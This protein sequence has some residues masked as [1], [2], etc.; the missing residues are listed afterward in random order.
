MVQSVPRR[1]AAVCSTQAPPPLAGMDVTPKRTA[2]LRKRAGSACTDRPLNTLERTCYISPFSGME[3][4]KEADDSHL[5]TASGKIEAIPRSHSSAA[6]ACH[7]AM[8]DGTGEGR[9]ERIPWQ[10]IYFNYDSSLLERRAIQSGIQMQSRLIK[11]R[12]RNMRG[13]PTS[14]P[15]AKSLI[16]THPTTPMMPA[17][18]TSP[19]KS[20]GEDPDVVYVRHYGNTRNW[21][22]METGIFEGTGSTVGT[23]GS[24]ATP[25]AK[26]YN[27]SS[28]YKSQKNTHQRTIVPLNQ[29]FRKPLTAAQEIGW[30]LSTAEWHDNQNFSK[31]RCQLTRQQHDMKKGNIDTTM[32]RRCKGMKA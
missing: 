4:D 18:P 12:I 9:E 26:E 13:P 11:N 30:D 22:N 21:P 25:L 29:R 20:Q 14:T 16:N 5:W 7:S 6:E 2:K 10:P 19:I 28:Y 24:I 3:E 8:G 1:N 15:V 17:H 27:S 23:I 32:M 31:Q